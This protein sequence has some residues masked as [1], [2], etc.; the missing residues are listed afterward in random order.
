[1]DKNILTY[2]FI[3]NI[4]R[5]VKMP[6]G[7]GGHSSRG[8]SFRSPVNFRNSNRF[9]SGR[10]FDIDEYDMPVDDIFSYWQPD[11]Y[12]QVTNFDALNLLNYY[13]M[14][15]RTI[16]EIQPLLKLRSQKNQPYL[17]LPENVRPDFINHNRLLIWINSKGIITNVNFM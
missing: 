10:D 13:Q 16:N 7:G 4:A 11:A 5:I 2:F 12:T 6:H 14:V 17:I 8:G 1:M 15:G 9:Y 3:S